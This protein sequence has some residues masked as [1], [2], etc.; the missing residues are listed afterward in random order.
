ME[1]GHALH[2]RHQCSRRGVRRKTRDRVLGDLARQAFGDGSQRRVADVAK[3]LVALLG[4]EVP[5]SQ[6]RPVV[7]PVE[8][9]AVDQ[10]AA[11]DPS[12]LHRPNG[13]RAAR[14]AA[15]SAPRR[16]PRA[17]APP[18]RRRGSTGRRSRATSPPPVRC[19][20]RGGPAGPCSPAGHPS[21]RAAA[22]AS[23][24]RACRAPARRARS[25]PPSP[26]PRRVRVSDAPS[27][28][29]M[30][31]LSRRIVISAVTCT[32]AGSRDT[33]KSR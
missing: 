23:R 6:H 31:I 28:K 29:P 3:P 21:R 11:R 22:P 2:H 26:L 7:V 18:P 15:R 19:R 27:D 8:E 9:E 1:R 33:V 12:P 24:R 14:R 10:L 25:P 30:T 17:R 20:R 32:F 5:G 4:G 16:P 13:A